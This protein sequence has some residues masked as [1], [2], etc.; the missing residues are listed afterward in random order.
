MKR[1][2]F[3]TLAFL[4]IGMAPIPAQEG[5]IATQ[6]KGGD[7]GISIF[8]A[9]GEMVNSLDRSGLAM[10]FSKSGDLFVANSA[11][12]N[13]G[14]MI[15]RFPYLGQ[16]DWGPAEEYCLVEGQPRALALDETSGV[17]Y[18]GLH[19]GETLSNVLKCAGQ[20]EKPEPYCGI[21]DAGHQIQDMEVGPDGKVWLGVYSEGYLRFPS[22]GGYAPE[23]KI[24]NGGKAG[25]FAIGQDPDYRDTA[26]LFGSVDDRL[27]NF[28]YHD[29]ETGQ[30]IGMLFSDEEM[31]NYCMTFGPDRN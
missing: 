4:G 30:Q 25:G 8:N 11:P 26:V 16:T 14:Y 1:E 20:G 18:I 23:F 27:E 10:V 29:C 28:G 19:E 17:L 7:D 13:N 3:I 2:I 5:F 24:L 22:E 6:G 9:K 12:T 21:N 31:K 15:W